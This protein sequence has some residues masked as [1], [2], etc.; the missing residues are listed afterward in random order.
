M[1]VC[2]DKKGVK[3]KLYPNSIVLRNLYLKPTFIGGVKCAKIF[4]L[5]LQTNPTPGNV[6]QHM[7]DKYH[8]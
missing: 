1:L 3:S 6:F 2:H 8:G 7:Q 4:N 5:N